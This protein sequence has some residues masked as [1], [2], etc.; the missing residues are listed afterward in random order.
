M[1]NSTGALAFNFTG[2]LV[3]NSI[4]A[5]SN[6]FYRQGFF[7]NMFKDVFQDVSRSFSRFL[8]LLCNSEILTYVKGDAISRDML[9]VR[10]PWGIPGCM[11]G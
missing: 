11:C 8:W 1:S 3:F 4:R 9:E 7:Y 2:A 10:G 6:Q 5:P